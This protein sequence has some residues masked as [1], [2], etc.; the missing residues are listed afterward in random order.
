MPDDGQTARRTDEA[1]KNQTPVSPKSE[2]VSGGQQGKLVR[3][4][5]PVRLQKIIFHVGPR[6][7]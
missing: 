3:T 5:R 1:G 4:R 2:Q 7:I 6:T